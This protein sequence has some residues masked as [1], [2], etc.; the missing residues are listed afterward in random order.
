[1]DLNRVRDI[2]IEKYPNLSMCCLTEYL[3]FLRNSSPPENGFYS[4]RHH[5]LPKSLF[6]EYKRIIKE[7]SWNIVNLR[8]RDHFKA[9]YL[10]CK[11]LPDEI[12]MLLAFRFLWLRNT[13]FKRFPTIN[14][15]DELSIDYEEVKI[16][17]DLYNKSRKHSEESKQKMSESLRGNTNCK[18]K[19]FSEESRKRM[20]ESKKGEKNHKFGKK[21]SKETREKIS[22]A[23]EGKTHSEEHR[24][25]IRQS[26]IGKNIGRKHTPESRKK[27][28]E[29]RKGRGHPHSEESKEKLREVWRLKKI[30][31][32][33]E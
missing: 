25:K 12:K 18:G 26:C 14:T 1:M 27:I 33:P 28:S 29:S 15:L 22:R 23:L 20:S 17:Y 2:F 9:H 5:A 6:P 13:Y 24:E 10:L 16:K 8:A 4:E 19:K 11:I 30:R 7:N 3:E 31:N 21:N 32:N